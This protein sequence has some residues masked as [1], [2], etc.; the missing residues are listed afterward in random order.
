[1]GQYLSSRLL[2]APLRLLGPSLWAMQGARVSRD[3]VRSELVPDR[4]LNPSKTMPKLRLQEQ[5]T[6]LAL[7]LMK[8]AVLGP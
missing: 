2:K 5:M 6:R 8:V 4:N 1:M 3:D 7:A